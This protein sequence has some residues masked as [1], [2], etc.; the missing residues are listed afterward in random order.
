MIWILITLVTVCLATLLGAHQVGHEYA[1]L[2]C[3]RRQMRV[4]KAQ[5][6]VRQIVV[7]TAGLRIDLYTQ[8]TSISS[9][10]GK[11]Q[12]GDSLDS[13]QSCRCPPHFRTQFHFNL[14]YIQTLCS[15]RGLRITGGASAF[16][17]FE[18]FTCC[19]LQS[20]ISQARVIVLSEG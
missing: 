5:K 11:L 10:S 17:R 1:K 15:F 18:N 8:A 7:F 2:S 16:R 13:F 9:L 19:H 12:N 4:S 14:D 20:N 3:E 6:C